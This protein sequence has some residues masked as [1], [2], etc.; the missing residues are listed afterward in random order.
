M[1]E[2]GSTLVSGNVNCAATMVINAA[3]LGTALDQV[4]GSVEPIR[5]YTVDQGCTAKVIG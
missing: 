5:K 3:D 2:F 4:F 1:Q